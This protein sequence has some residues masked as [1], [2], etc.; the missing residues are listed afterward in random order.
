MYPVAFLMFISVADPEPDLHGSAL[1]LVGW[2]RIRIGYADS[3]PG[4][5]KEPQKRKN[6]INFM[7]RCWIFS[8]KGWRLVR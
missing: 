5:Q 8:F 1:I 7:L 2:I 6:L 4:G 3:D